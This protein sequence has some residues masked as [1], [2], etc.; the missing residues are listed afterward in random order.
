M[1]TKTKNYEFS[2]PEMN[3]YADV[4]VLGET[5]DQIDTALKNVE[6]KASD[7]Q[8]VENHIKNKNNPHAVTAEQVGAVK[9]DL[10][11][12]D[13]KLMNGCYIKNDTTGELYRIGMDEG[14][15]YV[16]KQE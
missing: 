16:V 12:F 11:N 1:A 14:G 4:T 9:T 2:K 7:T 10:S 5:F 15:L 13:A 8:A 6:E 3:D